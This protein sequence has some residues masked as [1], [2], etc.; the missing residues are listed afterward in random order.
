MYGIRS[1][2][3]SGFDATKMSVAAFV[4]RAHPHFRSSVLLL[5]DRNVTGILAAPLSRRESLMYTQYLL[6]RFL[7]SLGHLFPVFLVFVL[8]FTF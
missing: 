6:H 4:L 5:F 7:S 1:R 3:V 8:F 2:S